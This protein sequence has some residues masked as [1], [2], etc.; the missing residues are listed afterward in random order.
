MIIGIDKCLVVG[1]RSTSTVPMYWQTIPDARTGHRESSGANCWQLVAQLGGKCQ[2]SKEIFNHAGYT[3]LSIHGYCSSTNNV[4]STG[5]SMKMWH[6]IE[7]N[8]E[9]IVST[10]I[11]SYE[12]FHISLIEPSCD[13]FN[14]KPTW[15]VACSHC[16]RQS[17]SRRVLSQSLSSSKS[18]SSHQSVII[19]PSHL[20]WFM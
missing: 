14:C 20:F 4:G 7:I 11:I 17:Y 18:T 9:W 15:K 13:T 1:G 12:C 10:T 5:L 3:C 2:Q 6:T 19:P 8:G 16:H